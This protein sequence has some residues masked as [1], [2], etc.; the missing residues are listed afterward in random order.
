MRIAKNGLFFSE[1]TF[2]DMICVEN[3]YYK[4][5]DG[6]V[7]TKHLPDDNI[8]EI[9]VE[10]ISRE[11][12]SEKSVMEDVLK[13]FFEQNSNIVAVK[14]QKNKIFGYTIDKIYIFKQLQ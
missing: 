14:C 13:N 10:S 7:A 9:N 11:F 2:D 1:K 8:I 6:I 4:K 5:L 3:M 12:Y